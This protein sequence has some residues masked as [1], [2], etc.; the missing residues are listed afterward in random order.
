MKGNKKIKQ[1]LIKVSESEKNEI[2]SKS[3]KLDMNVSSYVR[4][5]AL[6]KRIIIKTDK[7]MIRQVRYIGNNINQIAH[8][9]NINSDGLLIE[10][11]YIQLKEYKQMLQAIFDNI[12]KIHC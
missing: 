9:L 6:N 5:A 7:E 11:A 4:H 1:M 8:Q 12:E 3:D 2:K 10:E